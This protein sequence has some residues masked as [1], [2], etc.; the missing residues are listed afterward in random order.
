MH[1]SVCVCVFVWKYKEDSILREDGDQKE[2]VQEKVMGINVS[3]MY[4]NNERHYFK[5]VKE[6]AGIS[7]F[8]FRDYVLEGLGLTF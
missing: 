8:H 7:T 4:E 1:I 6:L 2:R 5:Q 3:K